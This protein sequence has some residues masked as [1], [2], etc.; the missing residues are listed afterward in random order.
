M[1]KSKSP[2]KQQPKRVLALPRPRR[3][4]P[5]PAEI[6][7]HM[8]ARRSASSPHV[9]TGGPGTGVR[10][11][12]RD[13]THHRRGTPAPNTRERVWYGSRSSRNEDTLD[14]RVTASRQALHGE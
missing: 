2:E 6:N 5:G 1:P 3:C 14:G 8:S 10:P 13:G 7:V 9:F 12:R 11:S 4:D